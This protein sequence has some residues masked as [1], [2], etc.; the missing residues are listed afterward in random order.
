MRAGPA[1]VHAK[2]SSVRQSPVPTS[3][4]VSLS[5]APATST[6]RARDARPPPSLVPSPPTTPSTPHSRAYHPAIIHIP[7]PRPIASPRASAPIEPSHFQRHRSSANDPTRARTIN[8]L[9]RSSITRS[10]RSRAR[11]ARRNLPARFPPSEPTRDAR[12]A[13][14]AAIPRD[15]PNRAIMRWN[16][17]SSIVVRVSSTRRDRGARAVSAGASKRARVPCRVIS[18]SRVAV[19]ARGGAWSECRHRARETI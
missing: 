12:R 14:W 15:N 2:H 17:P 5:T 9:S 13:T 18:R 3:R 16:R 11:R 7:R 19:C 10:T 8:A 4:R 6:P 1:C